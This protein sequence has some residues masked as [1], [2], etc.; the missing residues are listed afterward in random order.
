MEGFEVFFSTARA[1]SFAIS[2]RLGRPQRQLLLPGFI[3]PKE[4]VDEFLAC[5]A[6]FNNE[7][8][9]ALHQRI[10]TEAYFNNFTALSRKLAP[11][12]DKIRTVGFTSVRGDETTKVALSHPA[13]A[14]WRGPVDESRTV[15]LIGRIRSADETSHRK[16]P[17]FGVEDDN[18]KTQNVSVP[19]GILQDIVK[20]YWGERVQVVAARRGKSRLEMLDI[21]AAESG[22]EGT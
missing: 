10:Q 13:G 12:G 14:A 18:G 19:P 11:D 15:T 16:R 4:V 7:E 5:V 20:P 2:I 22:G 1:A 6:H 3:G 17:V 8:T 21:E 9:D